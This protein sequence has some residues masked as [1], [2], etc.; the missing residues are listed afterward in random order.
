MPKY[1]NIKLL[2]A[3]LV[4]DLTWIM[5]IFKNPFGNMINKVQ[6]TT[7]EVKSSYAFVAYIFLY[8][9]A[10]IFLP[11]LTYYEA[12]LLGFLTYGVY[13]FTNL[14]TLKNWNLQIALIDTL[15]GGILFLLLKYIISN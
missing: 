13:D 6:G 5:L 12:F 8:I 7:M 3:L 4:I 1:I 9:M 2:I 14:A 11:K 15:W 10:V